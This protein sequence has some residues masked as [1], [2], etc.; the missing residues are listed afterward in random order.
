MFILITQF[1]INLKMCTGTRLRFF[2]LVWNWLYNIDR[3]IIC[4]R[5]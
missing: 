1:Q 3:E 5:V 2:N 4:F